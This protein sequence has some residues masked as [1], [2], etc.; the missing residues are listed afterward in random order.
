M[1]S[2]RFFYTI[3]L[4][5]FFGWGFLLLKF[6]TQCLSAF[7]VEQDP[8]CEATKAGRLRRVHGTIFRMSVSG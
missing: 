6:P 7:L 5:W 3:V 4:V 1:L 2:P 8:E